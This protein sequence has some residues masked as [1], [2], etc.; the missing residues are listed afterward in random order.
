KIKAGD[1][2]LLG[3][4]AQPL[5]PT[6]VDAEGNLSAARGSGTHKK[7]HVAGLTLAEAQAALRLEITYFGGPGGGLAGDGTKQTMPW[8]VTLGGWREEADPRVIDIIEGNG[9]DLHRMEQELREL[10]RS[11]RGFELRRLSEPATPTK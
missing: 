7:V 9:S 10:K 11:S 2:V 1:T 4:A 3:T 6:V 5:W 8:L